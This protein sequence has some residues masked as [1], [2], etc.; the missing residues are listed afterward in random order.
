MQLCYKIYKMV[1]FNSKLIYFTYFFKNISWNFQT[2][3]IN[4]IFKPY[5]Y[6]YF[7]YKSI[8]NMV[9]I[10]SLRCHKIIISVINYPVNLI[11]Y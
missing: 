7:G 10:L 4:S 1:V 3:K 11:C 8:F 5:L 6:S 9:G 2:I